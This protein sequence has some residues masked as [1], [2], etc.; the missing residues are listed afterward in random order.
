MDW[1]SDEVLRDFLFLI[2]KY[3]IMATLY[4]THET[5][6]LTEL[7]GDCHIDCGIHPNY[8]PLLLQRSS[9]TIAEVLLDVMA[10]VP[11]AKSVRS[12]ALT[13]SSI[14]GIYYEQ[15]GLKYELNNYIPIEKGNV[16]YPYHAPI[17]N[18]KV[19]PF[20]FEDDCYLNLDNKKDVDFYLGN[21]FVAPRIFNFHPIHLYLNTD[22][23][24]TY[25]NARAYFKDA[26]KLSKMRN[27][28]HYGIRDFFVELVTKAKESKWDS[29]LIKDGEW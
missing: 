8:N 4:V 14:I 19:I 10:I 18:Y 27:T 15:F 6:M 20:I 16:I 7:M 23:I 11:E 12:H 25:E 3:D 2:N 13:S 9:K 21:N 5:E 1:A 26:D 22:C 28:T 24:D 29:K 17:G